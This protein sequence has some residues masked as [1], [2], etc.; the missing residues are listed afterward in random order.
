MSLKIKMILGYVIILVMVMVQSYLI[1][2]MN[3]KRD[4]MSQQAL[5]L[6]QMN[7]VMKDRVV[8][9]KSLENDLLNVIQ[10]KLPVPENKKGQDAPTQSCAY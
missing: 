4:V 3:G 8:E 2:S 1:V 6:F 5:A 7:V 9:L 10:S